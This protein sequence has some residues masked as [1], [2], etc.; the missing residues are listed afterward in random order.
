MLPYIIKQGDFLEKIAFKHGF[1]VDD[2]WNHP[3]NIEI[4]NLRQDHNVLA[5]GDIVFIPQKSAE[6]VAITNGAKNRYIAKVPKTNVAIEF[7]SSSGPL[8][9]EPYTIHGVGSPITGATDSEG[10]MNAC[11]PV[12]TDSFDVTFENIRHTVTILIGHID[13]ISEISGVRQRLIGL[14]LLSLN[15]VFDIDEEARMTSKAIERFQFEHGLLPTG[16]INDDTRRIIE[17]EFGF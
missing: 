14:G 15:N 8:A 6:H 2:V 4:R 9:N 13:P 1:T 10:N 3:K 5:P 17:E 12:T 16:S 11:V 7:F